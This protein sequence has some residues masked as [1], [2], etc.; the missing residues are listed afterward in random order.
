MIIS[1]NCNN[2]NSQEDNNLI[3]ANIQTFNK[4]DTVVV[5]NAEDFL[6]SVKSNRV[7]VLEEGIYNI[8]IDRMESIDNKH[9]EI[10]DNPTTMNGLKIKDVQNFDL[11]GKDNVEIVTDN[12]SDHVLII[13]NCENLYISNITMG[14]TDRGDCEGAVIDISNCK[15]VKFSKLDLYGSGMIG[16]W[17]TNVQTFEIDNCI[18]RECT[19]QLLRLHN[20][21]DVNIKNSIFKETY[22]YQLIGIEDSTKNVVFDNCEIMNNSFYSSK[23]SIFYFYNHGENLTLKNCYIHDN[24]SEIFI[25]NDNNTK[26]ENCN[27]ENNLFK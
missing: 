22:G 2:A 13:K 8:T 18:I 21:S 11:I 20:C 24:K 26:I 6:N 27:F 5:N 12:Q 25:D 23:S 1:Y 15:S 3:K 19:E 17:C 4:K 9:V 7:I 10:Q 14:H 16:L